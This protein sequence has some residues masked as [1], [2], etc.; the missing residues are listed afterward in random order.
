MT[1]QFKVGERYNWKNQLERLIYLRQR[2]CWHQFA[3]VDDPYKEV[4]CEVLT[5]DL[6]MLEATK[7]AT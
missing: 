4:W 5:P 6:R 7:E 2:G 1:T 3:K